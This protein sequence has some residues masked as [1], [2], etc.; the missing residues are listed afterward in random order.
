MEYN[1]RFLTFRSNELENDFYL[2]QIRYMTI[3][4]LDA[5]QDM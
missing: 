5:M 2:G 3:S 4:L 1:M